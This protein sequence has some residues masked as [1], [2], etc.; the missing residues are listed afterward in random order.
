M[1]LYDSFSL[2]FDSET[3][4]K[5][6]LLA[7]GLLALLVV[8]W[9]VYSSVSTKPLRVNL[10]G[11]IDLTTN[12]AGFQIKPAA[13]L[14]ITISNPFPEPVQNVSVFV[15]PRDEKALVVFPSSIRIG[16]LD[17]S[18]TVLVSVRPNPIGRVLSGT[19]Q[20]EVTAV[21]GNQVFSQSVEVEIKNPEIQQT[22]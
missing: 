12:P 14:T 17:K 19:Y 9:F 6:A 16:I 18:R 22:R 2:N 4:K 15:K 13:E 10:S 7:G 20:L 21:I 1:G 5:A 11:M 3:V 8:G